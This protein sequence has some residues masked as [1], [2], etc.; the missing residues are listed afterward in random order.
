MTTSSGCR[1]RCL[2]CAVPTRASSRDR[3]SRAAIDSTGVEGGHLDRPRRRW[4]S[5][6][7]ASVAITRRWTGGEPL[8][9]PVHVVH[10]TKL[11]PA[12]E[13]RGAERVSGSA[14][15]GAGP[16]GQR[17]PGSRAARDL[18]H[19]PAGRSLDPA[20]HPWLAGVDGG[21]RSTRADPA[22]WPAEHPAVRRARDLR[23]RCGEVA[24]RPEATRVCQQSLHQVR[25]GTGACDHRQAR[26][27]HPGSVTGRD[28]S[29]AA[30]TY[31][32]NNWPRSPSATSAGGTPTSPWSPRPATTARAGSSGPRPSRGRSRSAP[33]EPTSG[34]GRGSA[35]TATG[36]TC[37]RSAKAWSTPSPAAC[38]PTTSRRNGQR[39]RPSTGWPGGTARRFPRRWWPGSSRPRWRVAVFPLKPRRRR[40]LRRPGSRKFAASARPCS[41]PS[42]RY[43]PSSNASPAHYRTPAGSATSATRN[44]VPHRGA[45]GRDRP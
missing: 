35:T 40:C 19:R 9:T 14:V 10:I 31:T 21:T 17:P 33:S 42:L 1:R 44:R 29:L 41:R 43:G 38:T 6:T 30:G 39:S 27:A 7:S 25:R 3:R 32:R 11:C 15:A 20:R 2:G 34:T 4:T 8:V 24:W 12:G 16:G 23:G 36:W 28:Q 37:T 22:R 26:A 18:R 5:S 13:P 45:R